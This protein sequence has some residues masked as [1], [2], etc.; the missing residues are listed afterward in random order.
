MGFADIIIGATLELMTQCT[1]A[2]YVTV[3]SNVETCS[4]VISFLSTTSAGHQ[5]IADLTTNVKRMVSS[6]YRQ[7]AMGL[8]RWLRR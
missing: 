7:R 4:H 5:G 6:G 1:A 2:T 8:W 3:G